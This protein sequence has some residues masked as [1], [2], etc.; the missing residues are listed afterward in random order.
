[1]PRSLNACDVQ[2]NHGDDAIETPKLVKITIGMSTPHIP[3]I[4]VIPDCLLSTECHINNEVGLEGIYIFSYIGVKEIKSID[5]KSILFFILSIEEKTD[6][7]SHYKEKDLKT[8]SLRLF[9]DRY[10]RRIR[11]HRIIIINHFQRHD[12]G[13]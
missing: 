8:R 7:E 12:I 1:M 11:A 10:G 3:A 9:F 13:A 4:R 5:E 6:E 2:V